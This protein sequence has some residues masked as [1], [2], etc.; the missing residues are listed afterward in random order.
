MSAREQA[1]SF[2]VHLLFLFHQ[3][4]GR[5]KSLR[6]ELKGKAVNPRAPYP[7]PN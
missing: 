4:F 2:Q 5:V 3:S 1:A 6:E 7:L